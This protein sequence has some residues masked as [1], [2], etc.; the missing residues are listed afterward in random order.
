[1]RSLEQRPR[2][3]SSST[4]PETVTQDLLLKIKDCTTNKI[5]N[6][7]YKLQ[8]SPLWLFPSSYRHWLLMFRTHLG[9]IKTTRQCNQFYIYVQN[10]PEK[11][12]YTQSPA[13]GLMNRAERAKARKTI[14]PMMVTV[15][16]DIF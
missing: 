3:S 1:M 16:T 15:R 6:T 11:V 5:R 14:P 13:S 7:K 4:L 12:R 2:L 9:N 10:K 8:R